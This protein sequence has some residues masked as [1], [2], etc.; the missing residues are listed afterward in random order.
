MKYKV[1]HTNQEQKGFTFTLPSMTEQ[2]HKAECEINTIIARYKRTGILPDMFRNVREGHYGDFSK[3]GD[4]Q[5]AQQQVKAAEAAF[6]DLPAEFRLKFQND[7][8]RFLDFVDNPENH[9]AC[10]KM[11]IFEAPL[12]S[13]ELPRSDKVEIDP[14]LA[15]KS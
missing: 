6:M 5:T 2:N 3:V 10:V 15:P 11:G 1:N 8:V 7:P 4:F 9:D 14:E 12:I 13:V